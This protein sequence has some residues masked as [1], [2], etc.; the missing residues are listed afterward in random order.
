MSL[1]V[2][3]EE[4]ERIGKKA[5]VIICGKDRVDLKCL[6]EKLYERGVRRLL[7]EGGGNLNFGML[8]DG[9]VDEVRVAVAPMIVG[10]KEAVTLVEG[11]GFS[12]IEEGVK[13]HLIKYYTLGQ[14]LILEYRVG[15]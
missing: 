13:L 2:K 9:L 11:T 14:D 12:K 6:M 15:E 8:R 1:G 4:A 5:E 7:L 3:K 10:G